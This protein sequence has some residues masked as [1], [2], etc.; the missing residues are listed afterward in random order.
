MIRAL[1]I[2]AATA[3]V[4][5]GGAIGTGPATNAEV[6]PTPTPPPGPTALCNDGTWSY[7]QHRS[8]T[9]SHHGGVKQWCP[10]DSTSGQ[11]VV[12]VYPLRGMSALRQGMGFPQ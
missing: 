10:C 6:T 2:A 4:I 1:L 3:G 7:S 9:C 12:V 5:A 8:G 11:S